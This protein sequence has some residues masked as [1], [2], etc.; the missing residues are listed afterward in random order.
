[1]NDL[2]KEFYT[3]AIQ[4][5]DKSQSIMLTKCYFNKCKLK[6]V[7]HYSIEEKLNRLTMHLL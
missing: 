6:C 5:Y 7:Y 3:R 2:E 1:M 4:L